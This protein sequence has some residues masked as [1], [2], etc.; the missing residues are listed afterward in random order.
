MSTPTIIPQLV[1]RFNQNRNLYRIGRYNETQLRREFL[2]PFF[3][4]LGWDVANKQGCAEIYKD[5]IHEDSLEIEGANKAPDYAFRISGTRKFFVEAKKPAVNIE[6]NVHP[7][8]QLR[9]YAWSAKLPLGILTDFEEFAVYD[10]RVKPDKGDKA[11]TGRIHLLSYKDYIDQ[12]DEIASIFSREAVLKGSFD[13]Y[14]E[15]LQTKKGTTEVDDAFLAEIERWRDLLAKNIALRNPNLTVRELNYAVQMTIDRIVFLRI[16]EDRGIERDEQ[17]KEISTDGNIYENLCQLFQ[18]AD[19]RYNSGLFH[20]K[21]EKDQSSGA[22]SLTLDLKIDDQDLHDI[23]KNLYYPESPYVFREIPLDIL[24]QVYERFLGKIIRLT[25]GHQAKIEE[26]PE[27]RKAGGVYYTPTYIV[28][29]IVQNTIG[30]L[31]ERKN[32]KD[33]AKLKILDPAC[34]SGT[35]TLGA[36]QYLL[37]WHLKWYTEKELDKSLAGRKPVI[38]QSKDGYQLTT[39]KKKEIL[40][41]NIFGVDIDAQA[42]EVTKLSLLLKVLEGESQETI[43]SQLS[44]LHERVLPDLGKNIQ[45][46]NSLIGPDYYQ[47]QQLV[48]SFANDEERYRVNAF[49]WKAAF[50]QVFAQDG[51]DAVIG[52]PPYIRIQTLQETS[53]IDVNFFKKKYKAASKGNYDIYVVFVEKGLS[54]LNEKGK[55]GLILPHKFFNA[56]YGEPLRTL[57]AKGKHL[58]KVVHFGDQQVFGN[59]TTYTCLLF[60]DK[61]GQEE[62]KFEK[63]QDLVNWRVSKMSV[64]GWIDSKSIKENEWN[65]SVG[66]NAGIFQ[67]LAEMPLKLGDVSHLFVGLQTDADDVYIVDEIRQDGD[68]VLCRSKYTGMDHWF[69]NYHLKPFL[70]GSLNIR[71]YYLS[72]VTKRLIF[73]YVTKDGKSFLIDQKEYKSNF[74]LTW[75]YLEACKERLC[76]RN[77]GNMGKDW[78]GYVYK[79]N[80]TRFDT[81]KLLVPSIATGSCFAADIKGNFYFVGSGGGGGGGYGITILPEIEFSHFYLLGVLNSKLL[82]AYLR[83][84]STPFQHGYI[85]LN[86]QY[87]EQLPIHPINFSNP[88]DIGRHDKIVSLVQRMLD[89]YKRDPRTPQEQEMVKREIDSTDSQIDNLVYDLYGL[90]QEEEKIIEGGE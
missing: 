22:D 69:E 24:G 23:L 65:F 1:Q 7:A 85:A 76:G 71:R 9:R 80:H 56:Q 63:V 52:N 2:D 86:R 41:N 11:S 38:Y 5:V 64:A 42:V 12:W 84:I 3:E 59:A 29:Y 55:L 82:S 79:K 75:A 25:E 18:R 54:L 45:C 14:A 10:C 34:G 8:F 31:L 17:L 70:K 81:P 66:S 74:P 89:L 88:A 68:K 39:A 60:L 37:D 4:A 49:D 19:M 57:I 87:I 35:F 6:F 83:S 58:T 44:L 46:G 47:G 32:P 77:K 28:D 62:F 50:P 13:S 72:N 53:P 51:F 36:Y 61:T 27:V 16:C 21:K 43:G 30:I 20:F 73:P 15:S 33:V 90:T 40:L 67:K 78:Y 26:K 48:M